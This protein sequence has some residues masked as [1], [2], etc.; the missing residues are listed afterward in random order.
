MLVWEWDHYYDTNVDERLFE[1]Y[2]SFSRIKHKDLAPYV[3]YTRARGMRWPVVE[4][5]DGTWKETRFRFVEG[6]DPHVKKG[7]GLQFYHST[8]KDDRAQI[9][10]HPY[11]APPE[12]PDQGFPFWLCTGR[13]LEHWHTGTMTTRIP[14]L[15][16]SMPHA[17]VEVNRRDAQRMGIANGDR[18]RLESKRGVLELP[19]WIDGRGSPP[20]GSLFIPFFDEK[21]LCNLLTLDAHDPF[22]KQPDY[23]KCA[24][25]MSKAVR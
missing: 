21:L 16:R 5:P 9:W 8:S 13:V 7:T 19:A 18:V 3:E 14:Q 12:V 10:F 23:K 4:Q 24:V 22:S 1:E 17:Y 15:R 11:T 6:E 2:R 25:K 20:P